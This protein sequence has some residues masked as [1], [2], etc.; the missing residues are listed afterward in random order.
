MAIYWL[1]CAAILMLI[2]LLCL[3]VQTKLL[4]LKELENNQFSW[5]SQPHS[6]LVNGTVDHSSLSNSSSETANLNENAERES[7]AEE[8]QTNSVSPV[9]SVLPA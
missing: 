7:V 8:E 1:P 4:E 9:S 2:H 6:T 3:Q 5:H